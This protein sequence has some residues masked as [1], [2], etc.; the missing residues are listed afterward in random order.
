MAT[1]SCWHFDLKP[2]CVPWSQEKKK[3]IEKLIINQVQYKYKA[4]HGKGYNFWKGAFTLLWFQ[5]T[6]PALA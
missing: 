1:E 5:P 4:D 2:Y 3:E 6:S